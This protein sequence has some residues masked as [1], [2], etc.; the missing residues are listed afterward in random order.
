MRLLRD[1]LRVNKKSNTSELFRRV[2][3]ESETAFWRPMLSLL[4]DK[5]TVGIRGFR[6]EDLNTKLEKLFVF[7]LTAEKNQTRLQNTKNENE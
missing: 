6:L 5:T 3:T 4:R 1:Q 2:E 7:Y